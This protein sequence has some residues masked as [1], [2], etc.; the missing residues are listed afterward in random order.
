MGLV[1]EIKGP[2]AN[3]HSLNQTSDKSFHSRKKGGEKMM[4]NER[5]VIH[6]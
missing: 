2:K 1:K 3:H 4:K 6:T 5:C